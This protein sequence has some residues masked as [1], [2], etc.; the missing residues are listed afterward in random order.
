MINRLDRETAAYFKEEYAKVPIIV[1]EKIK[2]EKEQPQV[3]REL[4]SSKGLKD[5]NEFWTIES[6]LVSYLGIISRD[7]W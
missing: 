6:R 3:R 4:I 7:T 1:I 2:K 5:I